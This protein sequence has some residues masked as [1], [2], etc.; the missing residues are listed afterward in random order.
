[1]NPPNVHIQLTEFKN[2]ESKLNGQNAPSPISITLVVIL[3]FCPLPP[4][5]LWLANRLSIH[6]VGASSWPYW[7]PSVAVCAGWVFK[8]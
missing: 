5:G 7:Y 2:V 8:P 4:V 3:E 6:K 1:M